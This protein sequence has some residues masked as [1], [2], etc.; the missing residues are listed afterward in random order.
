[1]NKTTTTS[2]TTDPGTFSQSFLV[3]EHIEAQV[4]VEE[5]RKAAE[6][7]PPIKILQEQKPE[8]DHRVRFSHD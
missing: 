2:N 5:E 4:R 8:G 1:M 6:R 3:L 7:Q